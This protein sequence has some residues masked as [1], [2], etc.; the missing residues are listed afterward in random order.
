MFQNKFHL[1]KNMFPLF[2]NIFLLLLIH[3]LTVHVNLGRLHLLVHHCL[4]QLNQQSEVM[5]HV[6][7]RLDHQTLSPFLVAPT[8]SQTLI[9]GEYLLKKKL[10]NKNWQTLHME[11]NQELTSKL[12]HHQT[13]LNG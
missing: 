12:W 6:S 9:Q 4:V 1:F 11:K 10:M 3:L 8:Q 5:L 2:L 7:K 13:L